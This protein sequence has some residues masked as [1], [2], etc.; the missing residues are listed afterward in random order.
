MQ[1][2]EHIRQVLVFTDRHSK[3]PLL[4]DEDYKFVST[5]IALKFLL[6]LMV[7]FGG[8]VKGMT[9]LLAM[10]PKC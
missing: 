10:A 9:G 1:S 4:K 6:R 3:V 5:D 8:K 7:N 2:I